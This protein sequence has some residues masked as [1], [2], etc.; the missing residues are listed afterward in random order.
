MRP[1]VILM[2]PTKRLSAVS[3]C[4]IANP[5]RTRP[6]SVPRV[7]PWVSVIASPAPNGLQASNWSARRCSAL[8][9]RF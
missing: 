9:R 5:A 7:K 8:M 4:A 2:R 3:C 6:V 1:S